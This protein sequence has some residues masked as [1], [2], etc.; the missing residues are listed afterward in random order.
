MA[1]S[2]VKVQAVAKGT[3]SPEMVL[4]YEIYEVR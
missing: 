4:T 2:M 1:E 3:I